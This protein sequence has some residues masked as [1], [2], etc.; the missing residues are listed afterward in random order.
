MRGLLFVGAIVLGAATPA[1]ADWGYA[2]YANYGYGG[3]GYGYAAYGS[4][5]GN[6][7]DHGAA[8]PHWGDCPCCANA[9]AGYCEEKA[10]RAAKRHCNGGACGHR[11][12]G[13]KCSA[14]ACDACGATGGC[15]CASGGTMESAPAGDQPTPP[16]PAPEAAPATPPATPASIP[17]IRST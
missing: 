5:Y 16:P 12:F 10:A 9:W 6:L 3:Y 11:H 17:L 8:L 2:G 7:G 14:D 4:G 15:D 1:A 13:R